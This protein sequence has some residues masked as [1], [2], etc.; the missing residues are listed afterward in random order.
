MKDVLNLEV[1][2][3][4]RGELISSRL[5]LSNETDMIEDTLTFGRIFRLFFNT[6]P[7]VQDIINEEKRNLQLSTGKYIAIHCRVRHPKGWPQDRPPPRAEVE[8]V[9]DKSDIVFDGYE[10][11]HTIEV[12][13]HAVQCARTM[14]EK[15]NLH[16][17]I[18]LSTDTFKLTNHMLGA[19]SPFNQSE[20]NLVSRSDVI[21]SV[22][23]DRTT[24]LSL[25]RYYGTFV[26]L[27]LLVDARCVSFGIGNF[28]RFAAKIS[29]TQCVNQHRDVEW[30]THD[31][32]KWF[33]PACRKGQ[34]IDEEMSDN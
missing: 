30:D 5:Q 2:G 8:H 1:L 20:I 16:E 24:G 6:H 3:D 31:A 11:E 13:T 12:A 19:E 23:I 28:G 4:E 27:F 7:N 9:A 17:P 15:N 14:L 32:P 26:D 21:P 34:G 33:A 18:Y 25:D 10:K 22:H 29:G